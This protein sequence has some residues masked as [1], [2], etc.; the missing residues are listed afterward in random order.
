[1]RWAVSL[2]VVVGLLAFGIGDAFGVRPKGGTQYKGNTD[3]QCIFT[4]SVSFSV[5]HNRK[6]IK[7][8]A[9]GGGCV[10][11]KNNAMTQT[12]RKASFVMSSIPL[13]AK[14][15]FKRTKT[16]TLK[17]VPSGIAPGS[18][19][20]SKTMRVQVTING[21]F[22]KSHGQIVAAGGIATHEYRKVN[23]K[24]T[25]R[26]CATGGQTWTASPA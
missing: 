21:H 8:F 22:K 4:S 16:F 26:G 25:K 11:C 6:S 7:H 13:T 3:T 18:H 20:K 12:Y 19:P 10:T 14:G 24:F 9:V 17:T 15:R 23:G 1:M 2:L 5:A